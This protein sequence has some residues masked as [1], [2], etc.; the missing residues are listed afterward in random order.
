MTNAQLN[1]K[2]QAELIAM[3]E[4]MQAKLAAKSKLTLKVS[5]KGALS[6]YGMGRFP[7]TLY[8]GQWEKLIGLV[9]SGEVER[10]I[11]AHAGELATKD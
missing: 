5:E 9:K 7:V 6:L 2:S 11:V 4:A 10:F 1:G 8:R 3:V